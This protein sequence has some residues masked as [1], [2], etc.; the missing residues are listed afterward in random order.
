MKP[1]RDLFGDFD[2]EL[3]D[4][5]YGPIARLDSPRFEGGISH[6]RDHH[7]MQRKRAIG[8]AILERGAL[9]SGEIA[10]VCEAAGFPVEYPQRYPHA[11]VLGEFL[12]PIYFRPIRWE[13]TDKGRAWL[14]ALEVGGAA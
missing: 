13:L 7:A 12:A 6:I 5:P 2:L 11:L 8:A 14:A 3:G 1:A 10:R 9:T 4:D